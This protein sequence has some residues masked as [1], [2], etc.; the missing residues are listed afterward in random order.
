MRNTKTPRSARPR[1]CVDFRRESRLHFRWVQ[2]AG[3]R[4]RGGMAQPQHALMAAPVKHAR[5]SDSRHRVKRPK[6]VVFPLDK[7]KGYEAVWPQVAEMFIETKRFDGAM[8]VYVVAEENDGP[9]KIGKAKDPIDRLRGMQ[10]GNPRRL[11][12]EYVLLGDLPIEKLLHQLW[13]P[14]AITSL[15]KRGKVDAAPGTEWFR[16]EIRA[17]LFPIIATAVEKQLDY[18][19]GCTGNVL[20]HA[21]PMRTCNLQKAWQAGAIAPRACALTG[22]LGTCVTTRHAHARPG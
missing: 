15:A 18:L 1:D 14:Y 6:R 4:S 19:A 21:Y 9:V 16:P 13:E 12:I 3:T 22:S 8:Y 11:R 17:H 10:T 20:A 5:T 2:S 7:A